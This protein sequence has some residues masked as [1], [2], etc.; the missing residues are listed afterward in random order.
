[1][2]GKELDWIEVDHPALGE[3]SCG[4]ILIGGVPPTVPSAYAY[5][6]LGAAY[7]PGEAPECVVHQVKAGDADITA[8][9][10]DEALNTFAEMVLEKMEDA[11]V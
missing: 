11:N 6:M 8:L 3:L 7:D 2:D 1:M 5:V 10:S 9:F 4:C